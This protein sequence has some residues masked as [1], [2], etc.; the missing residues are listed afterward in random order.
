MQS[1]VGG[2]PFPPELPHLDPDKLPEGDD[3]C[4]LTLERL[5]DTKADYTL[6]ACAEH[7]EAARAAEE[8]AASGDWTEAAALW[9]AEVE[10]LYETLYEAADSELKTVL[11]DERAVYFDYVDSFT[12]LSAEAAANELR[13]KCAFLCCALHTTPDDLPDSLAGDYAQMMDAEEQSE[14]GRVIGFLTGSDS[15]V[16]KTYAGSAA[17]AQ[18]NVL[19]LMDIE[20]SCGWDEVFT[21]G[22]QL[23]TNALDSEVNPIYK[24]ADRETRKF[25]ALWRI[26]LDSLSTAER[27]F[28]ELLYEGNDIA[29]EETL[30]NLYKDAALITACIK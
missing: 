4:R 26:S 18:R 8:A 25:I 5:S 28:L 9:R 16:A 20:K 10:E 14:S 27:P 19:G 15:A 2:D 21:R 17:Y 6:H 7:L 22:V 12:A 29:I 13:I 24:A 11:V 1:R 3:W 23:W 30:M